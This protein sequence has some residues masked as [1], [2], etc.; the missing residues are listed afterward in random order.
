MVERMNTVSLEALKSGNR[1][2]FAKLVEETSPQIYQI[3]L[4]ILGNA[5]DAEDALQET[6][7]KALHSLPD[8]EGRSNL[9]TWLYRIVVNEALMIIRKHKTSPLTL[10]ESDQDYAVATD[11]M[12]IVGW[13]SLPEGELLSNE[14]RF[15]LDKAVMNLSPVLRVVFVMR[16][17]QGL[18]I[19]QTAETL[20]ITDSTV[21][22]RLSRARL[23]LRQELSQYYAER[24]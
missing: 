12:K 6:Y 15:F 18:S 3:A 20:G 16:D 21:K 17:L 8:F 13:Q 19:Q 11:Q 24:L 10:D 9:N 5:Q 14:A 7:I 22:T 1:E 2:A 4:R 23:A